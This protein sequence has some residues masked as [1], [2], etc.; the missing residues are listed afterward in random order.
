MLSTEIKHR[1]VTGDA[2]KTK[3]LDMW[4]F[5]IR[6]FGLFYFFLYKMQ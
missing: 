1:L 6:M 3:R 2:G 5:Y 4:Q